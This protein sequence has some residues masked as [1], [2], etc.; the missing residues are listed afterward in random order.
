MLL[1]SSFLFSF[2]FFFHFASCYKAFTI[3]VSKKWWCK[4][5]LLRWSKSSFAT[6]ILVWISNSN[7]TGWKIGQ[8]LSKYT[9]LDEVLILYSLTILKKHVHLG[10]KALYRL[11]T[12]KIS[13]IWTQV[14]LEIK[15]IK[16]KKFWKWHLCVGLHP[17][18]PKLW[19][20]W[21]AP[22]IF[23]TISLQ[24]TYAKSNVITSKNQSLLVIPLC[25]TSP[26]NH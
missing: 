16:S 15:E 13:E 23:I 6:F 26:L 8:C 5:L 19:P 12:N 1:N 11:K 24:S 14:Y 25:N 10:A 18:T 21:C 7:C 2:L 4:L 9:P 20:I 22:Q 3:S 17:M